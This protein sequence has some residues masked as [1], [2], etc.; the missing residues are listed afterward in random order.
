MLTWEDVGRIATALPE[1]AASTSYG[2]PAYKMRKALLVRLKEDA[3]CIV[4]FVSLDEK[5]MLLDAAPQVFFQT[6]HY[7]GYPAILARLATLEPDELA[8]MLE[9]T[10][11]AKAPRT[12]VARYDAATAR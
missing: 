8:A 12:L 11:R 1:V 3:A 5:E 9:R 7:A 4:L 2:T 10:W 6:D